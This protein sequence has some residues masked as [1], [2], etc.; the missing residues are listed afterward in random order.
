MATDFTMSFSQIK[1]L[2]TSRDGEFSLR[3]WAMLGDIRDPGLLDLMWTQDAIK[4]LQ[5]QNE[6][7]T[8][9]L[10]RMSK[11]SQTERKTV[12]NKVKEDKDHEDNMRAT[13]NTHLHHLAQGVND[14]LAQDAH[15]KRQLQLRKNKGQSSQD[16][17]AKHKTSSESKSTPTSATAESSATASTSTETSSTTV[18]ST[19]ASTSPNE[20]DVLFDASSARPVTATI[21]GHKLCEPFKQL[22]IQAAG[23]VNDPKEK[24][25]VANLPF[26]MSKSLPKEYFPW[27]QK[28][29][30]TFAHGAVDIIL[31]HLFPQN[32]PP[33]ELDWANRPA[34]GSKARRGDPLKPDATILKSSMEVAY[35]EI[36]AP[37]DSRSQ[38]KFVEDLWNLASQ[39]RDQID[40]H[41]RCQRSILVIPCIQIF[42]YKVKLFKMEYTA[43]L[44]TWMEVASGYLPRDHQD[45]DVIPKLL[46]LMSRFKAILDDINV[47]PY[48]RTP[49][50]QVAD[51]HL[52]DNARPQPVNVTPSKRPFFTDHRRQSISVEPVRD[53]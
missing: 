18:S 29:E 30:D 2:N 24:V 36:K 12:F 28:N 21:M 10:N 11:M 8:K 38:S 46:G 3:T 26:F 48:L 31:K 52:P 51:E 35:V 14:D 32:T 27:I 34:S 13:V 15:A 42:G 25:S 6:R 49:P 45:L 5:Q 22:Q 23:V 41:L 20:T 43:G 17:G 4:L 47:E 37:K 50:C 44:Y 1:Y 16:S 9:I 7:G 19:P 53:K 33:Y 39:A 40:L